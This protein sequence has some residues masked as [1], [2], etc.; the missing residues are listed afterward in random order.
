MS[1]LGKLFML[2]AL[3]WLFQL[4]F[5]YKQ[6]KIFQDDIRELR[7]QGFMAVGMGGRRY[8]GGR[9]YVALAAN[10]H[11][12]VQDALVLRGFT[13]FARSK[14]LTTYK[15]F[16]VA[17]IASGDRVCLSEKKKVQEAASNSAQFILDHLG[18][19][20]AGGE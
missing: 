15:G 18:K 11:G 3:M 2:I 19:I 16:S 9:A 1:N 4:W 12:I 8:R 14:K 13:I 6:S 7:K 10:E 17:E 20:K 5:A